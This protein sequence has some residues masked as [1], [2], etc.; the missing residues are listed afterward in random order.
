MRT[1]CNGDWF[2]LRR[3]E[4]IG[5]RLRRFPKSGVR[6][7]YGRVEIVALRIAGGYVPEKR[8]LNSA[9]SAL[10]GGWMIVGTRLPERSRSRKSRSARQMP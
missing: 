1:K 6:R 9:G 2:D 3:E 4:G 7:D 10:S 8:E 5:V